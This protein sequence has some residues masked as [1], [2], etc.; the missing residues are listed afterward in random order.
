MDDDDFR[1]VKNQ[2]DVQNVVCGY[3]ADNI[4][5]ILKNRGLINE[6]EMGLIKKKNGEL[7]TRNIIED[8]VKN[9]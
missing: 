9:H 5:E 8:S 6:E 7:F 3:I 2:D 1:E 4:A